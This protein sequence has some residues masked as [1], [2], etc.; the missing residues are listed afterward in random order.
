MLQARS[1]ARHKQI[2]IRAGLCEFGDLVFEAN[3]AFMNLRPG[4]GRLGP[5][6]T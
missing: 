4:T 2:P 3:V 5:A 6:G 1:V